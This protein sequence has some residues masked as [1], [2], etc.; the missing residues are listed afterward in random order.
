[1]LADDPWRGGTGFGLF[2]TM[3]ATLSPQLRLGG[4][5]SLYGRRNVSERRDVAVGSA[6]A[7]IRYHPVEASGL[8][9]Q[10]G[11]GPGFS[12]LAGGP[13]LIESGGWALQAGLGYDIRSRSRFTITPYGSVVQVFSAGG[14]GDNRG[15]RARGPR[16]PF[17]LQV[18]LGFHWY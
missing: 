13:G 14:E 16:N 4:E 11:G 12:T 3:G 18:G 2:V 1:L 8:Y 15:I 10:G 5:L 7:V 9:V 6:S 17:Y